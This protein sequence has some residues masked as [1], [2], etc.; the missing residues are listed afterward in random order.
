M[1]KTWMPG[2]GSQQQHP[3]LDSRVRGAYVGRP[4]YRGG[5]RKPSTTPAVAKGSNGKGISIRD[6]KDPFGEEL[7][8]AL[9]LE[10]PVV[11]DITTAETEA[12]KFTDDPRLWPISEERARSRKK[13]SKGSWI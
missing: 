1:S 12:C 13:E 6:P 10:G 9:E 7:K 5:H 8:T 3:G 4:L 11:I 2:G